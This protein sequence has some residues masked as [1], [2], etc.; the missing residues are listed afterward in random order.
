MSRAGAGSLILIFYLIGFIGNISILMGWDMEY[1]YL[2]AE[3]GM[4]MAN[5]TAV[6]FLLAYGTLLSSWF[7]WLILL[8]HVLILL[9]ILLK[10]MH[11]PV[12]EYWLLGG[13]FL[14]ILLYTL[15]FIRKDNK[16][17]SD[18]LKVIWVLAKYT[19]VSLL[20]TNYIKANNTLFIVEFL[21]ILLLVVYFY[22]EKSK[23]KKSQIE[24]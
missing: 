19:S 2:M 21:L 16:K 22:E 13:A 12:A 20:F 15:F 7:K 9:G 10:I 24:S 1:Q 11:H 8:P 23:N 14:V 17:V 4:M 18:Y 6:I 5:I 3:K